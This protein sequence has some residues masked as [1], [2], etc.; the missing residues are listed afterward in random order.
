MHT[1]T[2][3]ELANG[4]AARRHARLSSIADNLL[5]AA[6]NQ[7]VTVSPDCLGDTIH[8]ET[9]EILIDAETME[10]EFQQLLTTIRSKM[11]NQH[12]LYPIGSGNP[13][14]SGII[15]GWVFVLQKKTRKARK[16]A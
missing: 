4:I 16:A 8:P 11:D 13:T 7:P 3:K 12:K 6:E 2:L 9:L 14:E 5:L 1:T 15:N 10:Q